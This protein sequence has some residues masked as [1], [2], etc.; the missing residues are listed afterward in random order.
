[1]NRSI[2][3]F[4]LFI[5]ILMLVPNELKHVIE[6]SFIRVFQTLLFW[7]VNDTLANSWFVNLFPFKLT[8]SML[9][10]FVLF[11][12]LTLLVVWTQK[13]ISLLSFLFLLCFAGVSE[14][15]Q[16]LIDSRNS[17]LFDF[18]INVTAIVMVSLLLTLKKVCCR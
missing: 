12:F 6:Q 15:S 16:L 17:N 1:M 2:I 4:G 18:G 10:H 5:L 11:V 13:E 9:G 8:I 14:A 7:N 3:V